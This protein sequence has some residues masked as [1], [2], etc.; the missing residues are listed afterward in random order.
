MAIAPNHT[1]LCKKKPGKYNFH[2]QVLLH[3]PTRGPDSQK[4]RFFTLHL[5][6]MHNTSKKQVQAEDEFDEERHGLLAVSITDFFNH[7]SHEGNSDFVEQIL[8]K[9]HHETPD[10]SIYGNKISRRRSNSPNL[11][12]AHRSRALTPLFKNSG[13]PNANRQDNGPSGETPRTKSTC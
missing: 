4:C 8:S 13:T 7:I 12:A 6:M 5:P 2:G 10:C 1:G 11:S 9:A 3:M